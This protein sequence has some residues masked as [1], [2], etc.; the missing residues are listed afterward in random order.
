[1]GKG[2][3]FEGLDLEGLDLEGLGFEGLRVKTILSV[4]RAPEAGRR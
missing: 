2:L 4:A 1:M 3:D